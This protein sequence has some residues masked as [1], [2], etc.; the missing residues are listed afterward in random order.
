MNDDQLRRYSRQLLLPD[1]D[2]DGQE[3]LLQSKA[4]IVGLGGLGSPV[5]MYLAASGIGTLMLCDHD[6]VD[7]SN[8][9]RQILHHTHDI[10][11][12]KTESAAETLHG[13]NPDVQLITLAAKLEG[14]YLLTETRAA[15]IV[16]DASDNYPTRYALNA[17]C[18]ATQTPL[19]SGSAIRM[20]GQV[21]TF[22]FDTAPSPCYHCLYPDQGDNRE[23]CADAGVLA[24][25][26]G[27]IGSIQATE[28]IKV[29]LNLGQTLH[30]RLL[31]VDARTMAW[32]TTILKSDPDCPICSPRSGQTPPLESR[33][34]SR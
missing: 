34:L 28:A 25:L 26:V 15:D 24:P 9:Q 16:I 22:R 4:L 7:L 17:A 2:L 29:L 1:I 27:I 12:S 6:E 19:I 3:R 14:E 10:G 32:R 8:L 20:A 21:T 31:Q 13:L 33:T 18:I 11:R 23:N 30:G 5:A